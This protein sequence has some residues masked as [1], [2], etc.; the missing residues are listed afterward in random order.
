MLFEFASW[1]CHLETMSLYKLFNLSGPLFEFLGG[2]NELNE[3]H[4]HNEQVNIALFI[5]FLIRS[6]QVRRVLQVLIQT[7][8]SS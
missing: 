4:L 1:F 5:I 6:T 7:F 8:Y 2:L 3:E